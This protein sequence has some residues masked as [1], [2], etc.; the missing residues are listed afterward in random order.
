MK[1]VIVIQRSLK[2]YRKIFYEL[3]SKKLAD[4]NIQFLLIYGDERTLKSDDIDFPT[5]IKIKTHS[6]RI[7]GTYFYYHNIFRFI[8]KSNLIIVEQAS[9]NL[10]NYILIILNLLRIKKVAFWGHGKNFQ[11]E[12]PYN[13]AE[14]I[15]K[16]L[17]KYSCFFFAYSELS[18]KILIEESNY[19]E[20]KI[21][22]VQNTIDANELL[23]ERKKYSDNH[24][25]QFKSELGISTNNIGIFVGSF[26]KLKKIDLLLESLIIVKRQILDFQMI[27]IGAGVETNI[28]QNFSKEYKW[29][30]YVGY[31]NSMQKV[32]YMMISKVMIM[33]AGV[34]LAIIDSFVFEVPLI[35]MKNNYHGPEIDYLKDDINGVLTDNNIEEYAKAVIN[36]FN[37]QDHI[38]FLRNGCRNSIEKYSIET[39]V[40]NFYSGINRIIN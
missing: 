27:F 39:M 11:A 12:N 31:K 26:Y 21:I 24:L 6:F 20:N 16:I 29:A 23:K 33:P 30:H 2:S 8:L 32:P 15:K 5:G 1:R 14:I 19:A 25:N 13:F 40:N 4:N 35:T 34:G 17:T 36:L 3:L 9:A 18:K 28:I 22:V 38:N 37:S 10:E 7:G